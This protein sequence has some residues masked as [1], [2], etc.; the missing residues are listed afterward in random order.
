MCS[1]LGRPKSAWH[2]SM[3]VVECVWFMVGWVAPVGG[4]W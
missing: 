3:D 4:S 2:G 1:V